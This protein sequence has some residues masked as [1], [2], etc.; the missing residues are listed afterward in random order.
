MR[1][2][3]DK[4]IF[5]GTQDANRPKV[6]WIFALFEQKVW[7]R[8]STIIGNGKQIQIERKTRKSNCFCQ[9]NL[10]GP[11]ALSHMLETLEYLMVLWYNCSIEY[12]A[13]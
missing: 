4:K 13:K 5:H 3:E 8:T 1:D 6:S 10:I 9:R 11:K 12:Y 7:L 2:V